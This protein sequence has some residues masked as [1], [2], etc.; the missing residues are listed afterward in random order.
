[1][2]RTNC[3]ASGRRGAA[4][5]GF[6]GGRLTPFANRL[7]TATTPIRFAGVWHPHAMTVVH[8]KDGGVMLHSP[9]L[10]TP[11]LYDAI[12]EVGPVTH[13]VAPNWFHDLYL[14][15]YRARY[16]DARF[17]GPRVL[18]RQH[19]RI[20]DDILENGLQSPWSHELFHLSLSS[21][22]SLEE[23]LFFHVETR[24][25]IVAD[26]LSNLYSGDRTPTFTRFAY[27]LVGLEGGLKLF[28]LLR[29]LGFTS[30]DSLKRV[31]AQLETWNPDRLI[32]GHGNPIA[33]DASAPIRLALGVSQSEER[34][35]YLKT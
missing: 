29:W 28:P 18:Q 5:D 31:I 8:L 16:P 14:R 22:L 26:F 4:I 32:V 20:I 1:M 34:P 11:A 7:W 33:C 30:R 19:P 35:K 17:W 12:A 10:L 21:L 25:L 2:Y 15:E 9:C 13:V 23:T 3:S 24:T 27:R 6:G